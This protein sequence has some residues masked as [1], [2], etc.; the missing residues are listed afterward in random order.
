MGFFYQL[1]APVVFI[2]LWLLPSMA[3]IEIISVTGDIFHMI[4]LGT[5]LPVV[6]FVAGV[7]GQ[8]KMTRYLPKPGKHGRGRGIYINIS[9]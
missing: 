3:F 4:N 7:H 5:W 2:V 1:F 6:L 8:R 9:E